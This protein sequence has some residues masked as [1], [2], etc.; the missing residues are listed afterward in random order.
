MSGLKRLLCL[1]ALAFL[2]AFFAW[3][4]A[5]SRHE[6]AARSRCV[7]N[8]KCIGL[9][10]KF[11]HDDF[12]CLPSA[13]IPD[14]QG[15][16]KHSWRVLILPYLEKT[17]IADQGELQGLYEAYD[18][19][20]PWNGPTNLKLVHRMPLIYGC[21]NDPGR[22]CR[23][24]RSSSSRANI[25]RFRIADRSIS[26]IYAARS[27]IR[28]SAWI[29]G[30]QG[31]IGWSRG[32]AP[33][34]C[35]D[36]D[37][38]NSSHGKS[39]AT[40]L[41]A[42]ASCLQ[43]GV[44]ACLRKTSYTAGLSISARHCFRVVRMKRLNSGNLDWHVSDYFQPAM[45]RSQWNS[46]LKMAVLW[47]AIAGLAGLF[48]IHDLI[49]SVFLSFEPDWANGWPGLSSETVI[50]TVITVWSGLLF[51]TA[52]AGAGAIAGLIAA[53][54]GVSPERQLKIY[55]WWICFAAAAI[56]CLSVFIFKYGTLKSAA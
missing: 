14:E 45:P 10:M 55:R 30:I 7:N 18:F 16:P 4:A 8:L 33:L 35:C 34:T 42:L 15:R 32:I 31:L 47:T 21:S 54:A 38:G 1:L 56:L 12:G 40:I 3:A 22:R 36:L 19:S 11:Y 27:R 24:L 6:S 29:R 9:A 5:F 49:F 50:S 51:M 13:F 20:E 23:Q 39:A 26:L 53:L 2:P 43:T 41:P 28:F 25:Q 17:G 52:A 46:K 44:F 37:Q 48:L